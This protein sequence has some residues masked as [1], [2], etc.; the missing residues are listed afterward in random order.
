MRVSGTAELAENDTGHAWP[1][2]ILGLES[3]TNLKGTV[4]VCVC[5]SVLKVLGADIN[6][7]GSDE[8]KMEGIQEPQ[9][10]FPNCVI[11]P[12]AHLFQQLLEIDTFKK[13]KK[14]SI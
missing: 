14:S 2:Q 7:Q 6:W 8:G 5:V 4:C 12:L 10:K 13:K 11:L 9:S 3:R 1:F